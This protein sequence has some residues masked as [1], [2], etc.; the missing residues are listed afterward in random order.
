MGLPP[1]LRDAEGQDAFSANPRRKIIHSLIRIFI[2]LVISITLVQIKFDYLEGLLYDMRVRLRPSPSLS[3]NVELVMID[4]ATIANMKGVPGFKEHAQ[5]L[6]ELEQSKPQAVVYVRAF[7][8]LKGLENQY[9]EEDRRGLFKGT[10]ADKKAF[11]QAAGR[12]Q[13][14]YLQTD[15]L[16]HAADND[17]ISLPNPFEKIQ[18]GSGPKTAD[19][20]I[21][22]KDGVSR[23]ALISYQGQPLLHPMLAALY[24]PK[25][26]DAKNIRGVVD[27]FDSEQVYVQFVKPGSFPLNKFE[28]VLKGEFD[29]SRFENKI[30]L[31]GDDIGVSARDYVSTPYSRENQIT[32]AELHANMFETFIQNSAPVQA[33]FWL[34][35]LFT[36]A[37]SI[38]TLNVVLTMKP[39]SGILVLLGAISG[40]ALVSYLSF[41][42]FGVWVNMAHPLL[43][44]F[45]CYYFFI[46]Y[47]LIIENR[48]SWEYYQKHKLLTQVEEL[49]TNFISMMSH[50]LKTPLA[51]IQGMTDVILKDQVVL[52]SQQREAVDTIR[53][54]STDLLSFIN[55]ILNYARI[56]SQ[57]VE[58]HKQG[59]DINQLLEEVIKRHEFLAKVKHVEISTELEPLFSISID[60]EL[61]K[62]VL[63]NLLE[64]AIKYCS[65]GSKVLIKTAESAGYVRVEFHDN[66]PGIIEDELPNIFMKFFRSRNA[67]VS[68]IKG[69]GLGLYLAKYFVELHKGRI[70]VTS[71]V[72]KGSTFTV[73]LPIG[74]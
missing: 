54:S 70:F 14:V 73:E 65:E 59:K 69:S 15:V 12:L 13:R 51:R 17:K 6:K 40:F 46:P 57:G 71:S 38:L 74:S 11:A 67:K 68:P 25:I 63:S 60:P 47:R 29:R 39:L 32:V 48:R 53:S 61:I 56:E 34:D 64:N 19:K 16:G 4:N 7:S 33:P 58:L 35:V 1:R 50:D 23:R 5:L 72:G 31:I 9:S 62:Q 55:S 41:W 37:I 45:I 36:I 26:A 42:P 49:K 44:V 27:I 18:I 8:M 20:N 28:K 24:N 30:V 2:G 22:A 3:G 66:G 10:E 52:S 43:A 21:L